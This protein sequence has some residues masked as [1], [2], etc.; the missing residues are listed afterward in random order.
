[1]FSQCLLNEAYKGYELAGS[2]ELSVSSLHS[3]DE[4][5]ARNAMRV[6]RRVIRAGLPPAPEDLLGDAE[7]AIR[8][9]K[10]GSGSHMLVHLVG[11][12]AGQF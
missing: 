6:V 5:K 7:G 4:V 8:R 11:K 3:L 9:G 1:M 2:D 10:R 12:L